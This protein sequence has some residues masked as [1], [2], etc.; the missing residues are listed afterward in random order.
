M[1]NIGFK[2]IK[3]FKDWQKFDFKNITLLTGTNNSGKSSVINAMQMLQENLTAKNLDELLGTEFVLKAKQNKYG[4][5]GSFVNNKSEDNI[6][7]FNRSINNFNYKVKVKINEGIQPK[8]VVNIFQVLSN[9]NELLFHLNIIENQKGSHF[10]FLINFK[11]FVDRFYKKCENTVRLQERLNELDILY[12]R[13]YDNPNEYDDFVKEVK[14]ICKEF[15]KKINVY[16]FNV[17]DEDSGGKSVDYEYCFDDKIQL[18]HKQT[19]ILPNYVETP[20]YTAG[21]NEKLQDTVE[22]TVEPITIEVYNEKFK[23]AYNNGIYNFSLLSKYEGF[24]DFKRLI[25]EYYEK[26]FDEACKLLTADL[27]EL[28]STCMWNINDEDKYFNKPISSFVSSLADFGLFSSRI[29]DNKGFSVLSFKYQKLKATETYIKSE[30]FNRFT[31]NEF[32][33]KINETLGNLLLAHYKDNIW[34]EKVK[35]DLNEKNDFYRL[36]KSDVYECIS[37]EIKNTILDFN[38]CFENLYVSSNRFTT[39]RAY[40]FNDNTDFTNLLSQI[41]NIN[42]AEKRN[43]IK[44]FISKWLKEF[45]IADELVLQPDIDTGNFKAFLKKDELNVTLADYGLGTNQLLP[46]LF[47]VSLANNATSK[48]VVIEEPEANLHPAMQ[49]KLADMFADAIKTFKIKIIAE[50]HSEYLIR[51]LQYLV[52]NNNSEVKPD[53]V[54]IYYF[55]KPDNPNVLNGEIEQVKKIEILEDGYLSDDFGT[56]FFDEAQKIAISLFGLSKSQNN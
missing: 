12:K 29:Q 50:T 53:D 41:E 15:N 16:K 49:S 6:I 35:F 24:E 37:E 21:S 14:L 23:E 26:S 27:I 25:C 1:N 47:S 19:D 10:E 56:G 32:F 9:K 38:L 7:G 2:N 51:K 42:D 43:N 52:A 54:V 39:K 30:T 40:S 33:D 44:I 55:N 48:T 8:G 3:V 11:Y 28:S 46:I 4:T 45:D 17:P 18:S 31:N 22:I 36:I 13:L 5:I 20:S 34:S